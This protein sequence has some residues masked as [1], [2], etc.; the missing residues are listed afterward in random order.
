[1]TTTRYPGNPD[2]HEVPPKC[3]DCGKF[4]G[5]FGSENPAIWECIN[6]YDDMPN[7]HRCRCFSC[8]V[9]RQLEKGDFDSRE[10]AEHAILGAIS[11]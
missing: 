2:F 6:P 3:H 10:D 7:Y 4:C 11:G 1:M 9:D 8:A 5:G